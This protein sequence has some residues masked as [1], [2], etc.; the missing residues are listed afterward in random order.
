MPL[1]GQDIHGPWAPAFA[2]MGTRERE[3]F[4]IL[5]IF[6]C[7]PYLFIH[8]HIIPGKFCFAQKD[9]KSLPK[10]RFAAQNVP[11]LRLRPGLCPRPHWG[12]LQRSPDP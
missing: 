2:G 4:Y 6:V 7:N 9:R 3:L 8:I 11:K 1:Q 12:S 10:T 5:S